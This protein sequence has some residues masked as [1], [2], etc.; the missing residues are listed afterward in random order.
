MPR[1]INNDLHINMI[2][3][4]Y[5][6]L[7][8]EREFLNSNQGVYKIGKSKQE[9]CKRT[10]TYPKG[11]KLIYVRTCKNC[12]KLEKNIIDLF[13]SK[14][15][16]RKEIG[17]EYFEGNEFDMINDINNIINTEFDGE[18]FQDWLVKQKNRIDDIGYL[19]KEFIHEL[20]INYFNLTQCLDK[21]EISD[22]IRILV[23]KAKLEYTGYRYSSVDTIEKNYIITKDI[24]KESVFSI[25]IELAYYFNGIYKNN[26]SFI[27]ENIIEG[28]IVMSEW[29]GKKNNE[30]KS[31]RLGLKKCKWPI[32]VS[33]NDWCT[34]NELI[35]NKDSNYESNFSLKTLNGA[36]WTKEELCIFY[37]VLNKYGFS[38]SNIHH[39]YG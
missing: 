5:I 30:Y 31:I 29:P 32:V 3:N 8:I 34:S 28:G 25:C 33:P 4:N 2:M 21:P 18:I 20:D 13:V 35:I 27:P 22:E 14:Y 7:I 19:S 12:D 26:F 39:F 36:A 9:N 1:L 23:M 11:S 24:T 6:Y 38:I 15:N 37:Y 10:I 17:A 16:L